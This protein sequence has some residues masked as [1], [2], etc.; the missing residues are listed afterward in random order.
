MKVKSVLFVCTGNTCRSPM[1]EI[2]LRHMLNKEGIKGIEI[3]S[4]GL[5]ASDGEPLSEGAAEAL[6]AAHIDP[7]PHLSRRL[8][9]KDVEKADLIL[10]MTEDHKRTLLGQYPEADKKTRLL[11]SSDIEDPI[12]G[13]PNDYEKCRIEIQNYLL[14][15]LLTLKS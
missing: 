10:V 7:E 15:L 11:G 8:Q 2:L 13:S 3:F 12:G 9:P 1:A 4:R 6:K 14:D 5:S